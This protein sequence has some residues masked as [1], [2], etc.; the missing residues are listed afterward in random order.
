MG[1]NDSKS[2][3]VNESL[4]NLRQDISSM[5]E[6][7]F[8]PF[9]DPEDHEIIVNEGSTL[10]DPDKFTLEELTF[11][12]LP[13]SILTRSMRRQ[14]SAFEIKTPQPWST[15]NVRRQ[16]SAFEL[17][18][19]KKDQSEQFNRG[20][21][22]RAS[23]KNRNSSVKD[24]VKK[25]E[26][27]KLP[28]EAPSTTI[29]AT[30]SS[31]RMSLSTSVLPKPFGTRPELILPSPPKETPRKPEIEVNCIFWTPTIN[32]FGSKKYYVTIFS[33][34]QR[35][36]ARRRTP[37]IV[38]PTEIE[39][40]KDEFP[41][42][43]EN[44]WMDASEFFNNK[45]PNTRAA[46]LAFEDTPGCKRSS[47]I[48]IRTEKRG[49]VS[50]NV[51]TFTKPALPPPMITPRKGARPPARTPASAIPTSTR[52][53]SARMGI[54]GAINITVYIYLSLNGYYLFFS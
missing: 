51:E 41:T 4:S 16:S 46:Q 17:A 33:H 30:D 39:E 47:I 34:F 9:Q 44:E 14:S 26:V 29:D 35:G 21:V 20:V 11:P 54:A 48:R 45:L 52:R 31:K 19:L 23:L 42:S 13:T 3:K 24:L 6:K 28:T 12:K 1:K 10:E 27:V 25:L 43:N 50:R 36:R 7:S 53:T 38:S 37:I 49:L 15:S 18:G 40:A 2:F 32:L 5:I 22:T 8:G